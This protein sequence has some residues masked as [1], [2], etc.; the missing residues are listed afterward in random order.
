MNQETTTESSSLPSFFANTISYQEYR[1]RTSQD[2]SAY[3]SGVT[4][5]RRA[6]YM[7]HVKLNEARVN[8][9][10]KTY[11]VSDEII[12]VMRQCTTPQHWLVIT[13]DWCG[14]SA[15]NLPY[16]VKIAECSPMISL[17]ILLRDD[18]LDVIDKYQTN[19]TRS[20]PKLVSF[21]NNGNELFTWGP[22][23]QEGAD[24][25][26][27]L[28]SQGMDKDTFLAE[29]QKWY[30]QNKGQAVSNEISTLIR[31]TFI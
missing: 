19:G 24:L 9:I 6:D 18:N 11:Q 5:E 22:R 23:P 12:D 26:A 8:R 20:I 17:R 14:D 3:E 10:E 31:S 27:R 1:E 4:P 16:I 25:V 21:D 29:L 30:S 15:Q 7:G 28:K 2:L 13:E